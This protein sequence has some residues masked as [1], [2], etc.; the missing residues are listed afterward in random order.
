MENLSIELK[1][2]E[3]LTPEAQ[4]NFDTQLKIGIYK[5]LRKKGLLTEEQLFQLLQLNTNLSQ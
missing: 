3:L 1:M 4:K 5:E 2:K